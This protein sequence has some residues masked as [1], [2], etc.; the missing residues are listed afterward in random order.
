M[1]GTRIN[2]L[3]EYLKDLISEKGKISSKDFIT[4]CL[5][6]DNGY[7]TYTRNLRNAYFKDFATAPLSHPLFGYLISIFLDKLI[8]SFKQ[9]DEITIFEFGAG[10]GT[11]AYDITNGLEAIRQKNYKYVA[12][13][14]TESNSIFPVINDLKNLDKS[15]GIILSNELFDALPHHLFYVKDGNVFEKYVEINNNKFSEILDEPSDDC[16]EKRLSDITYNLDNI[17]GEIMCKKHQMVNKFIS[18]LDKGYI[19]SI[20]YGMKEKDLFYNGKKNSFM[21]VINNHNFEDE[22][23]HQP[24]LSDITF[25]VDMEDLNKEF[26]KIGFSNLFISSQR[27]FLYNLGLGESL[28]HLSN[29]GLNREEIIKNRYAI[30]QLIKPNGMGNY[31]VRLDSNFDSS[32]SLNEGEINQDFIKMIPLLDEF[33]QRFELPSIYKQNIIVGEELDK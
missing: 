24:G 1:K 10:N 8:S 6:G 16:I 32:I 26:E 28:V 5:Y 19:L 30:N 20:D 31:F 11:L 2:N 7:Y 14:I 23:F 17:Q 3:E 29:L 33:P 22:Y 13:D 15:N 25:Q 18:V 12:I 27:Q 9:T 4:A 21:S